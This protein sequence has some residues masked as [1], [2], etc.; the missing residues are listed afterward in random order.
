MFG[1]SGKPEPEVPTCDRLISPG[2]FVFSVPLESRQLRSFTFSIS[3]VVACNIYLDSGRDCG[4][5]EP[6][7]A[8]KRSRGE[9]NILSSI[10][11]CTTS[12]EGKKS[13][14]SEKMKEGILRK[15]VASSSMGLERSA[16][17]AGGANPRMVSQDHGKIFGVDWN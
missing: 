7:L 14:D 13:N 6:E 2:P 1:G 10:S 11:G 9:S 12:H 5:S 15:I 4:V 8:K 3:N 17:K 16:V